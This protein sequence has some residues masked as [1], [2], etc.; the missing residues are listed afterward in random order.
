[1]NC[2]QERATC[3]AHRCVG[4]VL[5]MNSWMFERTFQSTT[6]SLSSP[7]TDNCTAQYSD[8]PAA[9]CRTPE[10]LKDPSKP[11]PPSGHLQKLRN[12]EQAKG[13][14]QYPFECHR[15][16]LKLSS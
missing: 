10:C 11:Q 1:M 8:E 12:A 2:K 14:F 3:L 9:T 6:F 15:I 4:A 13:V 7:E 5:I 16:K